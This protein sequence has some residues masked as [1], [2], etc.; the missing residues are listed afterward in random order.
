M[1]KRGGSELTG[2]ALLRYWEDSY[3]DCPPVG[4]LLRQRFAEFWYRI[5]TLPESKRYA[6]SSPEMSEIL[7]RHNIL[8]TS[9]LGDGKR[10]VLI[11]TGYSDSTEPV[12]SYQQL[13]SIPG[14]GEHWM[15]TP[16]H[17]LDNYLHLNYWHFFF[18][19]MTWTGQS[20]DELLKLV[21]DDVISNV[22][23]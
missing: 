6:D 4:Y 21:A 9:L 5:H 1:S 14:S 7:R 8:L 23:F 15:T 19:E 16:M 2:A 10:Y 11:T 13:Q 18:Y 3:P 20:M 17:I 12:Q 22:L